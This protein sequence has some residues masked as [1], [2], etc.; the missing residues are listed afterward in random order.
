MRALLAT[1][2]DGT[3]L[4]AERR[5]SERDLASLRDLA[6][7]GVCRAAVTGRS[8]H[9]AR[10]V[11]PPDFPIDYLVF[12]SGAGTLHWPTGE[13]LASQSIPAADVARAVDILLAQRANFMVHNLVPDN[14]RFRHHESIG[15]ATDFRRRRDYDPAAAR[16]L[17]PNE[18]LGEASQ[19][20]A[21]IPLDLARL[22]A[23]RAALADFQVVRTTSPL[24][25]ESIWVEIFPAGVSKASGCA[26]LAEHLRI[27]REQTFCLGN[28]YN[29]LDMLE[30]GTHAA[31]VANAPADLR[32]RFPATA[33]HNHDPLTAA[34]QTW[35]LLAK[36]E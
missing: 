33:S 9:S 7:A 11:L 36:T 30:W 25:A 10:R 22:A 26:W 12:S 3:L 34:C 20:L 23:L 13:L 21:V 6:A 2:L 14:H 5:A 27:P 17:V 19:L 32:A 18:P 1:D 15:E 35:G 31:V 4:S 24:D 29:D 28:D 8:L 16:P